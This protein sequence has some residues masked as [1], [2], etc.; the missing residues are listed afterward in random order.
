MGEGIEG[1]DGGGSPHQL[2]HVVERL[3]T[4]DPVDLAEELD[5]P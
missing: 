2:E 4:H 5:H 3:R 1:R